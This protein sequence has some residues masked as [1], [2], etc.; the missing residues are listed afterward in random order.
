REAVVLDIG[1]EVGAVIVAA[2]ARLWG[3]EIEICPAGDRRKRPDEGRGWWFGDWRSVGHPRPARPAWPHVAGLS[4]PTPAGARYA[5]GSGR[6]VRN[7]G[8]A[9]PSRRH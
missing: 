6:D 2:P 7:S 3:A 9:R 5:P 1:G 4:R 8:W